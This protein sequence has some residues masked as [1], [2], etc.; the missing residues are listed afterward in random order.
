MKRA[1][2]ARTK[3]L[4]A[5]RLSALLAASLTGIGA[6]AAAECT[7]PDTPIETDRPDVTNSSIVVPVG[8]LQNENGI[9]TSR[10]HGANILS[11]TNSRWRLGIAPCLEVL[12]D[13]PNYV[14]TFR[15]AG[16]SGF[17]DVAPAVKWQIS[18]LPSKFD[19]S[20]TAGAALPTGATGIS[21]PGV[22]PY[23]QIPWSIAL[24]DGWALNGMET[25][26]FM[27]A[28]DSKFTYQSTLVLEKEFAERSFLFLEYVGDFPSNGRNS[29]LLNSGGGYRIDDHHQIDFHVGVGLD[30]NAPNYIFGVGYSFRLDGFLQGDRALA[31]ALSPRAGL[32]TR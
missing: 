30:R 16:P 11:G 8:S 18:P 25:N 19:L 6:A 13:L 20:I 5:L 7:Q 23:L 10:D 15:G 3:L 9:D 26:F 12:I 29:Q 14:T 1:E 27:P 4:G 2:A 17:G 21:G 31:P 24:G 32:T 28:S 22:Q